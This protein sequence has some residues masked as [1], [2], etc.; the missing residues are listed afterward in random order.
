V[1]LRAFEA[2]VSQVDVTA[3]PVVRWTRILMSEEND[4]AYS[5][6]VQGDSV[7]VGGIMGSLF[8]PGDAGTP[9]VRNSFGGGEDDGFVAR[10]ESDAGISWFSYLGGDGVD[11]VRSV[12]ARPDGGISVVGNTNT[13]NFAGAGSG[14]DVYVLRMSPEGFR[15]ASGIRVGASGTEGT[16]GQAAIDRYGNVYVGGRTSSSSGFAKNAFDTTLDNVRDGFIAMVD[17]PVTD[18]IWSSYVGGTATNEEY[19]QGMAPVTGG[20][21]VFGGYSNAPNWLPVNV[22]V[23]RT[24]NGGTDGFLFRAVIDETPP[25]P[26]SVS[27]QQQGRGLTAS[28]RSFFDD[29]MPIAYYEYAIGLVP[30]GQETVPYQF[31]GTELNVTLPIFQPAQQGPFFF[32]VRATNAVGLQATASTAF[33]LEEVPPED[34]GTDAG[35]EDAGSGDAGSGDAGTSDGGRPDGGGTPDA[36]VDAGTQDAGADDGDGDNRPPL[37][38]SCASSGGPGSLAL[39]GLALLAVLTARRERRGH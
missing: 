2:F 24:S 3:A 31:M 28:W 5:A 22:G 19:V 13:T 25:F 30:R 38:W 8:F 36:G 20:Q 23:D 35:S 14:N 11:D 18:V 15:I 6:A 12:L 34:A 39:A 10:L 32:S 4:N 9:T 37:G 21:L 7:F 1:R 26:G 17:S 16:L 29:E 27:V 33:T